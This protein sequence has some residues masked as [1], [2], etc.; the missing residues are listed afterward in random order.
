VRLDEAL[1]LDEH[2]P[3]ATAGVVDAPAVGLDHLD[4]KL[5]H[6][7]GRVKFAAAL[8]LLGSKAVQEVL[9][10]APEQVLLPVL[11]PPETE[12]ANQVDELAEPANIQA[13]AGKVLRE[14]AAKARVLDLNGVHRPVDELS[15]LG[16]L[17]VREQVLPAGLR[18]NPEHALRRVLVSRF[19]Q[20]GRLGASDAVGS[21]LVLELSTALAEGVVDVLEEHEPEDHMLVFAGVHRAAQLVGG[22]PKRLFEAQRFRLRGA[23]VTAGHVGGSG[24]WDTG[25]QRSSCET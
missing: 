4:E 11:G 20:V 14:D 25:R 23:R 9:V 17:C 10:D 21:K 24:C 2:P 6:V 18:R 8:A 19:Q 1:G 3:R 13:R 15:D 16:L 12:A 7:S 22:L 5:D